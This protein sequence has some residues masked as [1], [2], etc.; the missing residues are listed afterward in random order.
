L[1]SWGAS[2]A[3]SYWDLGA[4]GIRKLRASV[5]GRSD[6]EYDQISVFVI[7]LGIMTPRLRRSDLKFHLIQPGP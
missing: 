5:D 1:L 4:P 6:Y 3:G 7:I 2:S